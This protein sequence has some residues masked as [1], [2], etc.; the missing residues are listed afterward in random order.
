VRGKETRTERERYIISTESVREERGKN[1]T[2]S[3]EERWFGR[4]S[5]V[6]R[7][8]ETT[9]ERARDCG[10]R[11]RHSLHARSSRL[12]ARSP[13]RLPLFRYDLAE[14]SLLSMNALS[15]FH[16]FLSRQIRAN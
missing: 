12:L 7:P 16:I 2:N 11:S 9:V 13:Q 10:A 8:R 4:G 14:I 1:K 5:V 6:R 3:D 15:L